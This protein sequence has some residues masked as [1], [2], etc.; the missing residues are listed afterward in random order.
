MLAAAVAG[1]RHALGELLEWHQPRI[2]A[3]CLRMCGNA[4]RARDLTQDSLVRVIHGLPE[5]AGRSRVLTWML[6][7]AMNVCLTDRRRQ[8]LRLTAS[9]DE[10]AGPETPPASARV[11]G[12]EPDVVQGVQ[13]TEERRRL[14][15]ALDRLEPE[16]RSLLL[17]RDGQDIDYA[18]I[19][20]ILGVP[21]GTLKSR[22]FR[23]RQALRRE[24]ESLE[25]RPRPGK[26]SG[27][28]H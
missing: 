25:E 5:F 22:L 7:V 19:A 13:L 15:Q 10:S 23:A 2:Y 26:T 20:E 18:D 14:A 3:V 6:R 12:R 27:Q 8:R 9:L 17:L 11:A 28:S 24:M 21:L 1:D 16:E 4:E